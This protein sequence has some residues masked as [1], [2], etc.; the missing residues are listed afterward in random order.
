MI[1]TQI[2]G[3]VDSN[4]GVD[5]N[6]NFLQNSVARRMNYSTFYHT[7]YQYEPASG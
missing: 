1:R 3:G 4:N 7:F 5:G 6:D 2:N